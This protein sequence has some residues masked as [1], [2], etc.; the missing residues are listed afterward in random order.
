MSDSGFIEAVF[1]IFFDI[2]FG[3]DRDLDAFI[4]D[5]AGI[6][7]CEDLVEPFRIGLSLLDH[8]VG[9]IFASWGEDENG[10]AVIGIEDRHEVVPSF[11]WDD[12][13]F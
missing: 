1:T 4:I 9:V 5:P 10:P 6:I 11:L 3:D 7:D 2:F 13:V 8:L 12:R